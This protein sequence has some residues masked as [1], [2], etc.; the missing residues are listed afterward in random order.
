MYLT[1]I[2]CKSWSHHMFVA[3]LFV[4]NW[5][6]EISIKELYTKKSLKETLV[7]AICFSRQKFLKNMLAI[8]V[9]SEEFQHKKYSKA[10]RYAASRSADLGDTLFLIGSQNT[11]DTLFF[12]LRKTKHYVLSWYW[13]WS[14]SIYLFSIFKAQKCM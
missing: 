3:C 7:N 13:I 1:M 2:N 5:L 8:T 6:K 4:R 12:D 11:W 9:G 14:C 10:L